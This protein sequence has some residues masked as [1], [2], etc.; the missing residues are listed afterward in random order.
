MNSKLIARAA[1]ALAALLIAIGIAVVLWPDNKQSGH[2]A[3]TA[4]APS[5][6]VTSTTMHVSGGGDVALPQ[7]IADKYTQYGGNDVLG[8]PT[9]QPKQVG[10]GTVQAFTRGTIYAMPSNGAH[11]LTGEILNTYLANGG[12]S[13]PLGFPISDEFQMCSSP[14]ILHGGWGA[15]TENGWVW[16]LDKGQ[17]HFQGYVTWK[18][19]PEPGWRCDNAAGG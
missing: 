2:P 18:N 14:E 16:W 3:R 5:V 19:H 17:D 10:N 7:T 13:G 8:V 15:E 12:P 9:G 6:V 11:V 4:R 1:T